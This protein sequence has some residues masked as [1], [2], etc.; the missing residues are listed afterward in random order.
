MVQSILLS[1]C[2]SSQFFNFSFPTLALF[3]LCSRFHPLTRITHLLPLPT[4][5]AAVGVVGAD[6]QYHAQTAPD[7]H[8]VVRA[9]ALLVEEL[10]EGTLEGNYTV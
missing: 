10:K 7:L 9:N 4:P 6:G 1:P 3:L 2:H 8:A 5:H